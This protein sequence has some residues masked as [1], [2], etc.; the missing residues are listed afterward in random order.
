MG[1]DKW[2]VIC[3]KKHFL[4]TELGAGPQKMSSVYFLGGPEFLEASSEGVLAMNLGYFHS[5]YP[6]FSRVWHLEQA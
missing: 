1:Q 4:G 6:F 3:I 2:R 5:D